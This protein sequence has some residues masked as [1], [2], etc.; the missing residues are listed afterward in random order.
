MYIYLK[1]DHGASDVVDPSG[2]TGGESNEWPVLYD[3]LASLD[4]QHLQRIGYLGERVV[5]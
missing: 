3:I 5:N 2:L 4:G 1:S